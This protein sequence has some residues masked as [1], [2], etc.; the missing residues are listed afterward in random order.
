MTFIIPIENIL[1]ADL[2]VQE[3]IVSAAVEKVY[4]LNR[5]DVIW[6]LNK[7]LSWSRQRIF[8]VPI[9]FSCILAQASFK[10]LFY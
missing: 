8:L 7:P 6:L 5:S 4:T 10:L 3:P 9:Y 1:Q 2:H